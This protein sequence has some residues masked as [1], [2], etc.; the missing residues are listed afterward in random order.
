MKQQPLPSRCSLSNT[1]YILS[2]YTITASGMKV[3]KFGGTSVGK[4]ERMRRVSD[5]I[6]SDP[7]PKI[8]VLSALAG[9][10]MHLLTLAQ[11]WRQR[12]W[13]MYGGSGRS[14]D[15]TIWNT[16]GHFLVLRSF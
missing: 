10:T 12:D 9:T 8:V 6:V 4:P 15:S 11:G 7:S 3:L 2:K 16:A 14:C 1:F 13:T 5:I